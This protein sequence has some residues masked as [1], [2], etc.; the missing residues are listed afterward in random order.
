MYKITRFR[1]FHTLLF[2]IGALI[3]SGSAWSQTPATKNSERIYLKIE[4]RGLACPFCAYGMEKAL[5]EVSGVEKVDI[6]LKKG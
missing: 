3:L 1:P 5:K 4:V 2:L 6:V